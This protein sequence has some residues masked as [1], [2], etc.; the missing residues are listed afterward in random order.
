MPDFAQ[1]G[2]AGTGVGSQ[3]AR[4]LQRAGD[5]FFPVLC[6]S[7][8]EEWKNILFIFIYDPLEEFYQSPGKLTVRKDLK[9]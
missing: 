7:R 6:G 3:P 5:K 2:G 1:L 9:P 4:L 8:D